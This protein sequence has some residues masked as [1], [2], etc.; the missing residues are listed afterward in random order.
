MKRVL[1]GLVL[2]IGALAAVGASCVVENHRLT[3]IDDH[4]TFAG[5]L[6]NDSGVDI[7]N[8]QFRVAFVNSNGAVVE[9]LTV[10][11]C[12]RS[13]QD[14]A[15]DFFSATSNLPDESTTLAT[16][17]L[18]NLEEDPDFEVGATRNG[19]LA[20]SDVTAEREGETLTVSGTVTN[21]DADLDD[22]AV[23]VVVRDEDGLAVITGKDS[24]DDLAESASAD[25]SVTLTVPDD[26]DLVD[27]VDI[28]ADGI[29]SGV[30]TDPESEQDVEI[31]VTATA[32]PVPTA[33]PMP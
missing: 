1:A 26:V 29:E 21:E 14:G 2:G 5:D 9:L 30:P 15:S 31:G 4:D 8:H 3:T 20:F 24:L 7:L 27:H 6:R 19:E 18:A 16:A 17:R 33:T 25:F 11:G 28:W 23:C 10:D 13:L 12:L 32:T 22:P